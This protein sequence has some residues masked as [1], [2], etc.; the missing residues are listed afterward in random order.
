MR[1]L[2]IGL[3]L[4]TIAGL[5]WV[6]LASAR[7]SAYASGPYQ[8]YIY[9][10]RDRQNIFAVSVGGRATAAIVEHCVGRLMDDAH[11]TITQLRGRLARHD[12]SLNLVTVYGDNSR[13]ELG[14]CEAE[15]GDEEPSDS[16]VFVRN[17]SAR[18]VRDLLNDLH[19]GHGLAAADR[20]AMLAALGL[21]RSPRVRR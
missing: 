12:Q 20:D 16:L 13:V 9:D 18:Q 14:G 11:D 4:A 17:A 1:T 10:N 15:R 8:F 6:T 5:A 2:V 21:D 19:A 7:V 3:A